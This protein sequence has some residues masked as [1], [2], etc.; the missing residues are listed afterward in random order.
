MIQPSINWVASFVPYFSMFI[1]LSFMKLSEQLRCLY[2]SRTTSELCIL[3][4]Y[5]KDNNIFMLI[6]PS[7]PNDEPLTLIQTK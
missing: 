6:V 3:F 1:A 4:S 7:W 5:N 2:R